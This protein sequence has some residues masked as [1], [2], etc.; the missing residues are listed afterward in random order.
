MVS[1]LAFSSDVP[2]SNPAEA[3]IFS[4]KCVLKRTKINKKR[5][6]LAHFRIIEQKNLGQVFFDI[7]LIT[8]NFSAKTFTQN[9]GA[10]FNSDFALDC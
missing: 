10:L 5:P 1:A 7:S 4:V 2:S 3:F 8:V 6:R 9:M